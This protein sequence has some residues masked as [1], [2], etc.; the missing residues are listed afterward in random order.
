MR[1]R[2]AGQHEMPAF[3]VALARLD[4]QDSITLMTHGSLTEATRRLHSAL[5]SLDRAQRALNA[6]SDYRRE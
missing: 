4:I 5:D 3:K 6:D 2:R 1:R